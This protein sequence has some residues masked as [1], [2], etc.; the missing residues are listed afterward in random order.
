MFATAIIHHYYYHH[1]HHH[2]LHQT[3]QPHAPPHYNHYY[4]IT[5]SIMGD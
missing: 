4:D 5:I 2:H 1:H 3:Y